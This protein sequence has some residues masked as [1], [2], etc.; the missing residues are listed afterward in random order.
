MSKI[1]ETG[2]VTFG[3]A[4]KDFWKGYFDFK[5]VSTRAGFWWSML[6]CAIISL[7]WN[8]I[9]RL[10]NEYVT[11]GIGLSLIITFITM[12]INIVFLIPS[13]TVLI[14]RIR[15]TGMKESTISFL[16][17]TYFI[18]VLLNFF[19]PVEIIGFIMMIG[20]LVISC[21]PTGQFNK[22]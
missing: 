10:C 14:R 22:E 21:L 16:F 11:Y 20:F 1:H 4:W 6:S 7:G 15:D 13:L 12:A 18:L 3:Q 5:G 8:A 19:I 2:K 17:T 9:V